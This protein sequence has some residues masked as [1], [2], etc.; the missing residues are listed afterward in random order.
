MDGS[1]FS[2]S[3]DTSFGQIANLR[4]PE[5][6]GAVVSNTL[7]NRGLYNSQRVCGDWHVA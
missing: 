7:P 5:L 6:P 4:L 3:L 2:G 1:S